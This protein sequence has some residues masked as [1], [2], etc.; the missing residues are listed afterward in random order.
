M[1]V[2][3]CVCVCVCVHNCVS[4]STHAYAINVCAAILKLHEP[5]SLDPRLQHLTDLYLSEEEM[6]EEEVMHEKL[7]LF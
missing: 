7:V 1:R 6:E 4:L 5:Q 2:C 3:V